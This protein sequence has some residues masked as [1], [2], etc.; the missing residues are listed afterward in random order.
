MIL[1]RQQAE[2]LLR[3]AGFD[4]RLT[5]SRV[6]KY[7]YITGQCGKPV[8]KVSDLEVGSKLSKIEREILINDYLIPLLGNKD[9]VN[10][11][12]TLEEQLV[13]TDK[14]MRETASKLNVSINTPYYTSDKGT[15]FVT[16][17]YDAECKRFSVSILDSTESLDDVEIDISDATP[18]KI[19]DLLSKQL[20]GLVENVDLVRQLFLKKTAIEEEQSELQ[21]DLGLVC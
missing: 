17:Y 1:L 9:K 11:Y 13:E 14:K 20:H 2:K 5:I 10:R 3:E 12:I 7:V 16:S 15:T 8:M 21:K 19:K 18:R 4:E 6:E